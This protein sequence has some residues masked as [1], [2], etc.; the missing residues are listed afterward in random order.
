MKYSSLASFTGVCI[1]TFLF[2][3]TTTASARRIPNTRLFSSQSANPSSPRHPRAA[4]LQFPVTPDKATNHATLTA[5]VKSAM[6][7][8]PPPALLV[9]PE[10]WNSPYATSAFRQYAEVLPGLDD[11]DVSGSPSARLLSDLAKEHNVHIIGGSVPEVR[12]DSPSLGVLRDFFAL[13]SPS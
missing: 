2:Q 1:S 4:L 3:R 7:S 11:Q 13:F 9:L 10:V 8:S 12:E 5:R 6:S